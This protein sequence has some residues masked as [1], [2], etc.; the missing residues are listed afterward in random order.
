MIK[1]KKI[2][3][4]IISLFILNLLNPLNVSAANNLYTDMIEKLNEV[5]RDDELWNSDK[6][7][8]LMPSTPTTELGYMKADREYI[9]EWKTDSWGDKYWVKTDKTE[10]TKL[11]ATTESN[12]AASNSTKTWRTVAYY[13]HIV[14]EK[15]HETI[16]S[17]SKI[18]YL[19][20]QQR[21]IE[22]VKSTDAY[23]A[24]N[25]RMFD[26]MTIPASTLVK[27]G[28][29]KNLLDEATFI[30][31][32]ADVQIWNPQTGQVYE[33]FNVDLRNTTNLA[34]VGQRHGMSGETGYWLYRSQIITLKPKPEDEHNYPD[35]IP[36]SS[37]RLYEGNAGDEVTIDITLKN[38]GGKD[39]ETDFGAIWE[40][41]NFGNPYYSGKGNLLMYEKDLK[42]NKQREEKFS[43][44]V[45]IPN[46][47]ENTR[48][49]FKANINGMTPYEEKE[50]DNNTLTIT[51]R[52]YNYVINKSSI[53]LT[54]KRITKA[55]NLNDVGGVETF[56]F[57]YDS[58]GYHE[59]TCGKKDCS[60]H[61]HARSTAVDNLY[62]YTVDH[63]GNPLNPNLVGTVIP[64]QP[65]YNGT[66]TTKGTKGDY[67][68][69]R[70]N[71][72]SDSL[73]PNMQFVVWRGQD[74]PTIASY[75][76]GIN[77][78]LTILGLNSGKIPQNGRNEAGGYIDNLIIKLSA[79]TIGDYWTAFQCSHGDG[80][81]QYHSTADESEYDTNVN[82][83]TFLGEEGIGNNIVNA[84][85]NAD[86]KI[87]S[88]NF[89]N[90][91]ASGLYGKSKGTAIKND[92]KK[93]EFYP[94]I[95]MAYDKPYSNAPGADNGTKAV[96]VLA[97]HKSTIIPT[98]FV[99]VGW[100]RN[101]TPNL[102]MKSNLWS[103]HARVAKYGTDNVLAGGFTYTLDTSAYKTKVG[104]S[105]WQH[106]MNPEQINASVS[107]IGFDIA[108]ANN[109]H[110]NFIK[111]VRESLETL[112]IEQ[113]VD[114]RDNVTNAFGGSKVKGVGTN[115]NLDG[116]TFRLSDQQKHH[117]QYNTA[118]ADKSPA[119][120]DIDILSENTVKTYYKV[121]A[122]VNG[123]V[124]VQKSTNGS[125]WTNLA[126]LNKTQN[127]SNLSNTEAIEL[128]NKTK[129]VDNI[130]N[131]LDRNKG[132]D[133]TVGNGPQWY[134]EAWDGICIVK[135]DTI[136]EIGFKEP[137]YRISIVDPKLTPPQQSQRDVY[138]RVYS[139]Q[140]RLNTKS[141]TR[142][143]KAEGYVG[144]LGGVEVIMPEMMNMYY[145]KL[146]YIPSATVEDNIYMN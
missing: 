110:N 28:L 20:L 21:W 8:S 109:S 100:V 48:I 92:T 116:K 114:S 127:A 2:V 45:K 130:I 49:E 121:G 23:K 120:A 112:D 78:P 134:N 31:Q 77:H 25:T 63:E 95:Q 52:P 56:T 59:W 79:N 143:T 69:A 105:T 129:L 84:D 13:Y 55:Y 26:T 118:I 146:W 65:N 16:H 76:E 75:K 141:Y 142:T 40:G 4:L 126:N 108:N 15:T 22:L 53:D 43:L 30:I 111:E 144:S 46:P 136:M 29:P 3:I 132:N 90:A 89:N 42:I 103:K 80:A 1:S 135:T 66:D 68:K 99:S 122:D 87:G 41:Q 50:Q 113:Y 106:Y 37:K 47:G 57:T 91:Q 35:F 32:T 18:D 38:L 74:M 101:Q 27:Q 61:R 96:N 137:N 24:G 19:P 94:Y 98:D 9:Y 140:F 60:G 86:F 71:G 88:V 67:G 6:S 124:Y 81:T 125:T 64:F 17:T 119:G 12:Y 104:V 85:T 51:V 107:S 36:V 11:Y 14:N 139:S 39:G 33:E 133:S 10:V 123:N 83:L 70:W 115:I 7:L 58:A 97:Q 102:I 117:F 62:N 145:S 93:I 128:N 72:G 5:V 34:G 73:T 82:I 54:Q 44:K 138:S 131:A